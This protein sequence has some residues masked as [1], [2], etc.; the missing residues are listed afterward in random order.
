MSRLLLQEHLSNLNQEITETKA[1]NALNPDDVQT[2]ATVVWN[3]YNNQKQTNTSLE[4]EIQ[5]LK[6]DLNAYMC[7]RASPPKPIG[8]VYNLDD[9]YSDIKSKPESLENTRLTK[10]KRAG[11]SKSADEVSFT[12]ESQEDPREIKSD[13]QQES[14]FKKILRSARGLLSD[15]KRK[16]TDQKNMYTTDKLQLLEK[17][18]HSDQ[19]AGSRCIEQI[20]RKSDVHLPPI[21]TVPVK[22]KINYTHKVSNFS[23]FSQQPAQYKGHPQNIL[24]PNENGR[25]LV[26][27]APHPPISPRPE[28]VRQ[29]KLR[30]THNL[31]S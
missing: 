30:T 29:W 15:R 25:D 3:Q 20:G 27:H 1:I 18:Y 10:D 13:H 9:V 8:D 17:R 23:L 21:S 19:N 2:K 14:R 12:Q 26:V 11:E 31:K 28:N 22:S 16:Q 7:G 5:K 4:K 6:S 24:L